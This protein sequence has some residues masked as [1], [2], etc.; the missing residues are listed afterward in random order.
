MTETGKFIS[1]LSEVWR[2]TPW[3]SAKGFE[4]G[5][6]SQVSPGHLGPRSEGPREESVEIV[7]AS[8]LLLFK[9]R[10]LEKVIRPDT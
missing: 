6:S 9:K 1:E 8:F 10:D 4:E 3:Q 5:G 7:Q 2:R